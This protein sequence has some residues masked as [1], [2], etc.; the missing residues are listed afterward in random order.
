MQ[1]DLE[2]AQ[3]ATGTG[4]HVICI[5]NACCRTRSREELPRSLGRRLS[6]PRA[7]GTTCGLACGRERT[8][9]VATGK[10]VPLIRERALL[11]DL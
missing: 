9:H 10:P 8:T 4:G 5:P 11:S 3:A 2:D 6:G 7:H 1:G